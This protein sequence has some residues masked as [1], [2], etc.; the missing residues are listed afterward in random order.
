MTPSGPSS[1]RS[2]SSRSEAVE[3]IDELAEPAIIA[4]IESEGDA[5]QIQILVVLA[6]FGSGFD[7]MDFFARDDV[8]E[9]L[10]QS[11]D[12]ILGR[13]MLQAND[14]QFVDEAHGVVIAIE[15]SNQ[16]N[17][18]IGVVRDV[19]KVQVGGGDELIAQEVLADVLA[20]GAP[21]GAAL[22]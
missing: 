6:F 12:G 3:D 22:A 14:Q 19:K 9:I 7:E 15:A 11:V 20:P 2:W 4:P 13:R 5:R 8:L 21:I 16:A 17:G 10:V 18:F 1:F